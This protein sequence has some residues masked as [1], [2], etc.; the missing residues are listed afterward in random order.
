[1][2]K[3]N[4]G[5]YLAGLLTEEEMNPA[6]TP[7]SAQANQ[8]APG[9]TTPM[10]GTPLGNVTGDEQ[11][12]Q[13]NQELDEL[14]NQMQRIMGRLLP[15]VGKMKNKNKGLH[16]LGVIGSA[17]Q[18]AFPQISDTMARKAVTGDLPMQNNG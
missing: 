7:Q 10:A 13:E 9:G 15:L 4:Y 8:M 11:E 5:L 1:M 3:D 16:V 18:S 2:K 6:T 14:S 12:Q 17:I